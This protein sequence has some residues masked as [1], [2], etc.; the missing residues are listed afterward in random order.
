MIKWLQ[1]L[2]AVRV[3]WCFQVSSVLRI[4]HSLDLPHGLWSSASKSLPSELVV[5]HQFG[6]DK[7]TNAFEHQLC[8][9]SRSLIPGVLAGPLTLV[10]FRQHPPRT[11][12]P[13]CH[14]CT[15]PRTAFGRLFSGPWLHV[16]AEGTDSSWF[17]H[18][19]SA[20]CSTISLPIFVCFGP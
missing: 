8:L 5:I 2:T 16:N 11:Y 20:E 6:E 15:D 13:G 7:S 1:R 9:S 3:V 19:A 17:I 14:P 10:L 12:C 18:R 4:C